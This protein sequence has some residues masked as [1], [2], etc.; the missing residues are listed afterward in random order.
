MIQ[1]YIKEVQRVLIKKEFEGSV[2]DVLGK[3]QVCQENLKKASGVFQECFNEIL[4]DK[5]VVAWIPSQL[6][7][8]RR[9]C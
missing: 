1:G 8:R 4:F 9:A 3:F 2:K 5:F 7:S 6:P